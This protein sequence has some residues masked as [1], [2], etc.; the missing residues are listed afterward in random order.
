MLQAPAGPVASRT[1]AFS[2]QATTG[3]PGLNPQRHHASQP[4]RGA[5]VGCRQKAWS[6]MSWAHPI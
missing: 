2:C 3:W 1:L 5:H 4:H 6:S